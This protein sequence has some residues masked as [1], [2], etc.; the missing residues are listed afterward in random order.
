MKLAELW[1]RVNKIKCVD[2]KRWKEFQISFSFHILREQNFICKY[3]RRI[4]IMKSG[5]QEMYLHPKMYCLYLLTTQ[6]ASRK[7]WKEY[8]IWYSFHFILGSDLSCCQPRMISRKMW[9]EFENWNSFHILLVLTYMVLRGR[10]TPT[11]EASY[12]REVSSSRRQSDHLVFECRK[13]EGNLGMYEYMDS[14]SR[15][16]ITIIIWVGSMLGLT[17]RS[18]SNYTP[19]EWYYLHFDCHELKLYLPLAS[20]WLYAYLMRCCCT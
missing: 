17:W 11:H 19:N 12:W 7:M 10:Y 6:D 5:Y 9:K 3:L 14:G 1:A 8:E 20:E 15:K 18:I 13:D 4:S 2:G 16:C